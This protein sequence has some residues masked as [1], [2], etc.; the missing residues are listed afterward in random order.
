MRYEPALFMEGG[1]VNVGWRWS[2]GEERRASSASL[3]L[4]SP[5]HV[6]SNCELFLL[7]MLYDSFRALNESCRCVLAEM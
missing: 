6:I 5:L 7:S 4:S 3:F 1:D 2:Y